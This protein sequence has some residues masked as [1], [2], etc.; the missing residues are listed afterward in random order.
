MSQSSNSY[1]LLVSC[2][3]CKEV[4]IVTIDDVSSVIESPKQPVSITNVHG[5][6]K[7]AITL[8][9]DKKLTVR[10][11]ETSDIISEIQKLQSQREGIVEFYIP[12]PQDKPVDLDKLS[13]EE[14][15]IVSLA[16]GE[17]DMTEIAEVLK[18]SIKKGKLL[19]EKLVREGKLKK[20]EKRLSS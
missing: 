8:F 6:P 5:N 10:A 11:V 12:H 14:I 9:V 20:V 3:I 19:A 18:I 17:K 4:I 16:D 2:P 1:D 7:H 13:K 15:I